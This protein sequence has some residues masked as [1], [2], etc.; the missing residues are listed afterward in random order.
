MLE[1]INRFII[2]CKNDKI[3]NVKC[4][5]PN[6]MM[7]NAAIPLL[8]TLDKWRYNKNKRFIEQLLKN[9]LQQIMFKFPFAEFKCFSL[10]TIIRRKWPII[11][12]SNYNTRNL[13][14]INFLTL[15][16][17]YIPT[18]FIVIT[19]LLFFTWNICFNRLNAILNAVQ[20]IK[21]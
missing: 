4:N 6:E 9:I 12:N 8:S 19:I 5:L 7:T 15:Y 18:S 2:C 14:E 21:W 10:S 20:Q 1:Q 3:K 17:K 11:V 16:L 13:Y